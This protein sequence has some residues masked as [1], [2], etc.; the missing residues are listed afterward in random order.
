M[1]RPRLPRPS[2]VM[3]PSGI[4]L[5][6][7]FW[8]VFAIV[9]ASRGDFTRAVLYVMI[10]AAADALDGRVA[11]ATGT[12]TRFGSELDSL[13]DAITFGLAPAMIMY[14]AVLHKDG[15]DWL[16]V[17]GFV[18]CAVIRLAR[19]NIEQ[20]GRAKSHFRGLPSP[21]AGAV[22]ASY[23]W[24]SQTPLYNE[25]A[26]GDLPWHVL[27][28]YLMAAL[29]FLMVSDIPYPAWPTFSLRN[30]RGV[31]G[32]LIFVSLVFGLIFLPREFFFPVGMLY[33][34]YGIVAGGVR[35]LLERAPRDESELEDRHR[36]LIHDVDE[37][38]P[39]SDDDDDDDGDD[40]D[41]ADDDNEANE[42]PAAE[43]IVAPRRKRRRRRR[44]RPGSP[45][46]DRPTPPDP[47]A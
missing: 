27:L 14:F 34:L 9:A 41:H 38:S 7:L 46:H 8:G 23:Y 12:N 17:F 16:F 40:D 22:L 30:L 25:T 21:A 28:R 10:G 13:V 44:G 36:D 6:S 4:T 20:A 3:L 1:R 24:F 19:F 31:I 45:P 29:A 37:R 2:M 18:A 5:F 32:L 35:G 33:V 39:Y 47:I 42:A 43:A 11:R 26:I 15:W